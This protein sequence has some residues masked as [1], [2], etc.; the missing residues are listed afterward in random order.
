VPIGLSLLLKRV[1]RTRSRPVDR[2]EAAAPNASPEIFGADMWAHALS[3]HA[4]PSVDPLWCCN[5]P[6]ATCIAPIPLLPPAALSSAQP[7]IDRP[8][9]S[10][11]MPT[12]SIA[13]TGTNTQ[14]HILSVA[15]DHILVSSH[16][17]ALSHRASGRMRTS[18]PSALT[19][20]RPAS[21]TSPPSRTTAPAACGGRP[22]GAHSPVT[23][24]L[25]R[26]DTVHHC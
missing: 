20:L 5:S 6:S 3:S 18:S 25:G 15:L 4:P 17:C 7:L 16:K 2:G 21:L 13:D 10:Q 22:C 24:A 14:S 23:Q 8:S 12:N 26:A 11:P 9:S 19:P 1:N